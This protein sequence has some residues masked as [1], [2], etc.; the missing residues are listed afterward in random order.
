[1]NSV[2]TPAAT[3]AVGGR[4]ASSSWAS[5]SLS[6]RVGH[7][8]VG[9]LAVSADGGGLRHERIGDAGDV[10]PVDELLAGLGDGRRVV[11]VVEPAVVG[12]EHD[13]GGL[14]ALAGEP[15]VQDV[16]G[17]LGLDAGDAEAVVELAAGATL[18]RDDGDRGDEPQAD[19]PERV[20]G[21]AAAEAEQKCAHGF[22]LESGPPACGTPAPSRSALTG[23]RSR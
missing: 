17:V 18:Q 19:H 21:A 2:C 10:V 22:L 20:T 8:D 4:L 5:V 13:A 6:T 7:V 14:A 1:M 15:V 12:V 11:G 23:P 3:G 9:R 16:G